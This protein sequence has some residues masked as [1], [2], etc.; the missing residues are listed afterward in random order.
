MESAYQIGDTLGERVKN[1]EEK[2][3]QI[4]AVSGPHHIDNTAS[5]AASQGLHNIPAPGKAAFGLQHAEPIK[6]ILKNKNEK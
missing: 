4:T 6:K 2:D 5:S 1:K 3:T